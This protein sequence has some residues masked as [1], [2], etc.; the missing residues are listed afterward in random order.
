MIESAHASL[1]AAGL[2]DAVF[3]DVKANPVGRNVDDRVGVFR[4]L[5]CDGVI[6]FGSGSVLDV[7]KTIAFM[8]G[9]TRPLWDFQNREDWSTRADPAGIAPTIAVPTTAGTGSEVGRATA[10][11]DEARHLKKIII[12][13]KMLPV[14][15]ISDPELT[16]GLPPRI[17]AKPMAS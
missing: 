5:G 1:R 2:D 16:V 10:I 13:P 17:T 15:V 9:Q 11:L 4:R 14:I 6:A 3:S 8:S 12:D 7:G